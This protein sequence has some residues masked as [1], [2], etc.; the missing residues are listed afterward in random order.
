MTS[1]FISRDATTLVTGLVAGALLCYQFMGGNKKQ[2]VI[3]APGLK[4]WRMSKWVKHNGILRTQGLCG[5]F[6][7]MPSSTAQQTA[8]ALKKLDGILQEAGLSRKHLIAVTIFISDIRK[9]NFEEM[10]SVYDKWVDPEGLPTRLC[11]QAKIGH[12][13][14][15]EFRAEAYCED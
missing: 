10:N 14:A 9:E 11:V 8:E 15:V 2:P 3:R 5:D 13:A 4:A 12:G 7:K 1:S 6:S